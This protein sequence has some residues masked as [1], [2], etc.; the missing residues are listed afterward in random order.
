MIKKLMVG[1]AAAGF[2]AATLFGAIP[3]ASAASVPA[4]SFPGNPSCSGGLKIEPVRAGDF[5][6]VTLYNVSEKS[7]SFTSDTGVDYVIVKGGPG[8]NVYD[9]GDN[10]F[11]DTDLVAP[12]NKGLSHLCFFFGEDKKDP[13]P[14][15]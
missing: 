2:A 4:K 12:N 11:G 6:G 13:D 14:K 3:A 9:Y 8:Y 7:F 1:V 10:V 5:N 15:K